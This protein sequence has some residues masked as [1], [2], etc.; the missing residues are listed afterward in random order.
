MNRRVGRKII[1][2]PI[3][4]GVRPRPTWKL[5]FLGFQCYGHIVGKLPFPVSIFMAA[6]IKCRSYLGGDGSMHSKHGVLIIEHKFPN[7]LLAPGLML[8]LVRAAITVYTRSQL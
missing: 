2:H 5:S 6:G 7:I 8:V 4:S 1:A 3:D